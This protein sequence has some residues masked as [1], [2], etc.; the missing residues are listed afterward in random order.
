MGVGPIIQCPSEVE[1][2][3]HELG[4]TAENRFTLRNAGSKP[5]KIFNVRTNC[6]CSGLERVEDAKYSRL[7]S[8][9]LAPGQTIDLAIRVGVKGG[10]GR[11][12]KNQIAF[13]TNDPAYPEFVITATI[14]K[15]TSGICASPTS[16]LLDT[17]VV[18]QRAAADVDLFDYMVP[19]RRIERVECVGAE[20]MTAKLLPAQAAAPAG[21]GDNDAVDVPVGRVHIEF[22]ARKVGPIEGMLLIYVVG[23]TKAPNGIPVVGRVTQPVQV[24]PDTLVLPVVT[25][26]G[27]RYISE[28]QCRAAANTPIEVT[29]SQKVDGLVVVATPTNETRLVWTVTV[30]DNSPADRRSAKTARRV[31]TLTV[32]EGQKSFDIQLP[33]ILA[34]E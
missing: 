27:P 13:E 10:L 16:V 25:A 29:V 5:L 7:E 19:P 21:A 2:G 3:E 24:T 18:G 28:V 34:Q 22:E 30:S 32:R 17:L 4:E 1:M 12:V 9:E 33:V 31:V 11:A 8:T 26:A 15:V 14:N 6:S 23:E 20:G